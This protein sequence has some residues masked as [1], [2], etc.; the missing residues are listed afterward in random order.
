MAQTCPNCGTCTC[1]GSYIINAA[2]GVVCCSK[3]VSLVATTV[4][5]EITDTVETNQKSDL[6][7]PL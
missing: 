1:T 5:P 2:N 7:P 4:A 3:C 6:N